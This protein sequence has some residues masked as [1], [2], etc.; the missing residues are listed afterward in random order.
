MIDASHIP[1]QRLVAI[2][3][4]QNALARSR[5]DPASVMAVV[6]ERAMQ[7]TAATG[8]VVELVDGDAMLYRV[9]CGS[10]APFVGLRIA[11]SGSL[12]PP[13]AA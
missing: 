7:L 8:A 9:A 6:V 12:A 10:V 13:S 5:F 4:I 2:I 11:R 3:E 1:P